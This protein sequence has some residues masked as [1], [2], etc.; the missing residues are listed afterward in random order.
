LF[1]TKANTIGLINFWLG[2]TFWNWKTVAW[3]QTKRNE[4]GTVHRHREW[5]SP[6]TYM[7]TVRQ[8]D[9]AGIATCTHN[10][11]CHDHFNRSGVLL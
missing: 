9:V 11:C 10:Y 3:T 5:D 1:D 4:S 8:A 2:P 7:Y 6:S